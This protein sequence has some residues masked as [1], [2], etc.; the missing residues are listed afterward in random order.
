MEIVTKCY[1]SR[2]DYAAVYLNRRE[3]LALKSKFNKKFKEAITRLNPEIKKD[4][5]IY[6]FDNFVDWGVK[7][8]LDFSGNL[9]SLADWSQDNQ[10]AC[11]YYIKQ[12]Q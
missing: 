10:E 11:R 9:D 6:G 1:E 5:D 2:L 4:L 3:Y 7:V 12:L 8:S